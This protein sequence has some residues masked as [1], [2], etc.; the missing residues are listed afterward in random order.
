[1]AETLQPILGKR[2]QEDP[3][4]EVIKKLERF[5][6]EARDNEEIRRRENV[7]RDEK[8]RR[9][10]SDMRREL[11]DIRRELLERDEKHCFELLERDEKHRCELEERDEKHR[12]EI[13]EQKTQWNSFCEFFKMTY[14][15]GKC[16]KCSN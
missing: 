3:C 7:E 12:R 11:A 5:I 2:K 14:P 15:N 10:L 1:M 16:P 8:H 13:E 9:E 6:A 4:A